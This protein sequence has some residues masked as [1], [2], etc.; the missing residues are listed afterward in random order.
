MLAEHDLVGIKAD[1]RC[2]HDLERRALL[3]HAILMDARLVGESISTNDCLVGL[4]CVPG[5]ARDQA[6]CA[7]ELCR[8]DVGVKTVEIGRARVEQHYE[9]FE[10]CIAGAFA[11]AVD[12]ALDLPRTREHTRERV[13]D[14][15]TKVIVA[16]R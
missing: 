9:L 2:V 12:C 14:R 4:N 1:A 15:E 6:T 13:G 5:Q 16:V 7:G 8:L 3:K 11:D 10:R